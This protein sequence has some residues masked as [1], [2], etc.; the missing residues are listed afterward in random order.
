MNKLSRVGLRTNHIYHGDALSI[1]KT[2]PDNFIDCVVTS[3]PYFALRD[4]GVPGQLGLEKKI[5]CE[6]K[7]NNLMK[8]KKGLNKQELKEVYEYFGLGMPL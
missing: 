7:N 3:P 1:L 6:I 2:F 5:D 4:Y 8:L